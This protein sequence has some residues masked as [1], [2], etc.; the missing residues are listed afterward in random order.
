MRAPRSG[1]NMGFMDKLKGLFSKG[2]EDDV[3]PRCTALLMAAA[4]TNSKPR[5]SSPPISLSRRQKKKKKKA[6]DFD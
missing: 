3:A 2:D 6:S 1:V 4:R 5:R